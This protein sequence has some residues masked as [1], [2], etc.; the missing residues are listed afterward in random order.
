MKR[1]T[2]MSKGRCNMKFGVM[3]PVYGGWVKGRQLDEPVSFEYMKKIAVE[4]ERN[5]YHSLWI[6]D[7]LLNPIRGE[8]YPSLEAW[9]TLAAL[10]PLTEHVKLAHATLC[11]A[12]RH[13]AILAKMSAT[14]D[15]ISNGRFILAMGACWFERE[16]QAYGIKFLSHNHRIE[17]AS[18]ALQLIKELWMKKE[19]TIKG[20][21]FHVRRANLEPKPIQKPRPPIWYG[22]TS[23]AS[24]RVAAEQADV[25]LFSGATPETVA[26]R[27]KKFEEKY[28]KRVEYAMSAITILS[29]SSG[30]AIELA[31][32]C[33]P[34]KSKSVVSSGLIGSPKHIANK[35]E[36]LA[37]IGI[38]YILLQFPLG[39]LHNVRKFGEEVLPSFA[40]S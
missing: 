29:E 39:T 19:V 31:G 35:I 14:L 25:W 38:N 1:L 24:E 21:H 12:F 6:P 2:G 27:V 18:E 33:F 23:K 5:E 32:N 28:S 15:N 20:K 7:H 37:Q 36:R 22:G 17:A 4:A 13:P 9:T 30:K 40:V 3:M 16:F 8:D 34:D 26:A 11:Y 10:A